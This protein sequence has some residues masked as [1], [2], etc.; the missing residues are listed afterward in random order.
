[1]P[2]VKESL[3]TDAVIPAIAESVALK[4]GDDDH[5]HEAHDHG[6]ELQEGIRILLV[7]VAAALVW[8]RVWEPFAHLS[9]IGIAGT[10]IGIY[11][12]LK[13]AAENVMERRMT[14][15][16]SMTIAILAA[17]AIGQFFTALIIVLFVLIAEVLEGLT[18]QRGRTAIRELLNLLPNEVTVRRNGRAEQRSTE[19]IHPGEIIEVNPGA[20]I[21]VDGDVVGG[22]SFVDQATITGESLPVEK[23]P[24]ASV[25]AGTVNQSGALE[26]R[27]SRIGRDTAFGRIL[28]A[29]EEAER[30]R[31]PIQKTADRLA[32]YLVWFALGCAVLTFI[33]TRNLT[34]TISVII[35]AGACGIAAGTPL[36]ILGGIGRSAREGAIIKG[37]LYLELLSSVDTVVFDKTGTLTFG[38]PEVTSILAANGHTEQEVLQMASIAEQR[39]EHPLGKAIVN[40]AAEAQLEI[41]APEEFKYAPGKGID[42]RVDHRRI[43]VGNRAFLRDNNVVLNGAGSSPDPSSEILVACNGVYL[44]AIG[45]A[46]TLRPEAK[47][48]VASLHAM[49]IRTVLLTGDAKLVAESIA[50]EV[51][52]EVIHAEVLPDQKSEVIRQLV[53]GGQKVAMVG[54]GINDAP[55]LMQATVGIAMGSGTEVARESAKIMLIGNNLL[56][57]VDTIKISRR[58]HRTIMQNFAGTLVV[59]SVGVGLAAFGILNPLLAA[60]IHVSSELT[61]ILNSARLLPRKR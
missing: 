44:G 6:F 26:I 11:P 37:G 40:K 61:F 16:L 25:F 34:S 21:P 38:N 57:L 43:L 22:N 32:G 13:E 47:Q 5:D 29:V 50:K 14:M 12:I 35:V 30:S 52:I 24:G 36:A 48:S 10:L 15:E 1:M 20:R 18:V 27:V 4:H 17:L 49:G 9:I 51:G 33:I 42:C 54:D 31:A 53:K 59:D 41:F 7:A 23:L 46:D 56:R 55:A 39:S 8:F 28:N 19:S 58:C 3:P 2:H 45:I 60:F